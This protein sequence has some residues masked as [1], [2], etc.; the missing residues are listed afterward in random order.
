MTLMAFW[1]KHSHYLHSY[2]AGSWPFGNVPGLA[3]GV[4]QY[5]MDLYTWTFAQM[6]AESESNQ[7]TNTLATFLQKHSAFQTISRTISSQISNCQWKING[8][9]R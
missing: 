6:I 7:P 3:R 8:Q 9:I 2:L 1:D 5:I 4:I